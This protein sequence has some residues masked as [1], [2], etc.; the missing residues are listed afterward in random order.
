M[1]GTLI[2]R[3]PAARQRQ[4]REALTADLRRL[5]VHAGQ[6]LLVHSSM[7]RIGWLAE[8]PATVVTAI[9]DV[10]GSAGTLVVPTETTEN[11][12]TSRAHL[13][14][15]AGLTPAQIERYRAAMRPFD[16]HSTPST[17]MGRVAEQV[18]LA[19]GAIRSEHP[20]SSF[21]ALG[22]MAGRLMADHRLDSHLGE[23]SPLGVMYDIGAWILL[24]G[25]GYEACTAFHL[26]EYK[27]LKHPPRRTYRCVMAGNDGPQ[28]VEYED[29]KLD[30][31]DFGL[32]GADLD[33]AG[34]AVRGRVGA[35]ECRL[36]QLVTA[37]DFAA[38]WLAGHRVP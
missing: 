2:K 21:A 29:V 13:D 31:S 30:D 16:R 6:V 10:L 36:V 27:Y 9:G 18:R 17:G 33:A 28:W 34:L 8:G 7:R 11:S 3:H 32:L 20:Q 24:L 15:I 19:P 26:A 35:A 5:G 38:G 1:T 14:R 25:V 4:S 22:P 37:V 12:D 23:Y